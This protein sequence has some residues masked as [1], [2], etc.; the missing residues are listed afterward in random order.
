MVVQWQLVVHESPAENFVQS[1]V[2]SDVFT[3]DDEISLKVKNGTGVQPSGRLKGNLCGVQLLWQFSDKCSVD[4][5]IGGD[6]GELQEHA[7]E[8]GLATQTAA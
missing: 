6:I 3:G 4:L 8:A 5:P 2:S 1:I 7:V